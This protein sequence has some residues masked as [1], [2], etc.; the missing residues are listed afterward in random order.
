MT[1][2]KKKPRYLSRRMRGG[3]EAG[4]SPALAAGR[5]RSGHAAGGSLTPGQEAG[6]RSHLRAASEKSPH[7]WR[8]TRAPDLFTN[9]PAPGDPELAAPPHRSLP[10]AAPPPP[11]PPAERRWERVRPVCSAHGQSGPRAEREQPMGGRPSAQGRPFL[12]SPLPFPLVWKDCAE[13]AAARWVARRACA[14]RK[15]P[16]SQ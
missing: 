1:I 7:R 3:P 4:Q 12:P 14:P 2:A 9:W 13:G 15:G 10:L 11:P 6:I 5:R 16:S 8:P